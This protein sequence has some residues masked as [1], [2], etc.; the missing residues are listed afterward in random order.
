M[1]ATNTST[2]FIKMLN[3]TETMLIDVLIATPILAVTNMI[4]VNAKMIEC[5][6]KI[7]ANKRIIKANGLVKIP[8][9]SIVRHRKASSDSWKCLS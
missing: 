4:L 8:N 6:A 9:N 2:Q 3:S 1:K 5:P 7:L